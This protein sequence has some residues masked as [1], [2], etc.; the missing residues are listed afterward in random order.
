MSQ[1][2]TFIKGSELISTD[3][4]KYD[5]VYINKYLSNRKITLKIL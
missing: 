2:K 4:V 3:G 5:K 1:N